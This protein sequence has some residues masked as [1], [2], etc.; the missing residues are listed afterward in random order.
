MENA[1]LQ[2]LVQHLHVIA[3][4]LLVRKGIGLPAERVD[5]NGDVLRGALFRA[6]EDHVLDKVRD[7]AERGRFIPAA[8]ADPDTDRYRAHGIQLFRDQAHAVG[9]NAFDIHTCFT[10][11]SVWV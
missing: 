8:V 10:N 6:L 5:R 1:G 9:E 3:G 2:A 11:L 4:A 7:A